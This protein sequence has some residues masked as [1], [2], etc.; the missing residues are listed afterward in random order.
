MADETQLIE[1]IFHAIPSFTGT[2]GLA[3]GVPLGIADDAM[4]LRG[5]GTKDL[6]VTV[7]AFV[8]GVHFWAD[9]HPAESVG[10]KALVRATSDIAAMG[11]KPLFF[12]LTLALPRAR[13]GRW[14]DGM[15]AGMGRSAR[16]LGLRLVGGDTTQAAAISMSLTVIGQVGRGRAVTRAGARPGDV[17]FVSG[18]LGA[19]QLG[20]ELVQRKLHRN[21]ELRGDIRP[22]FYP[23]IRVELGQ[24]LGERGVASAMIDLSDGLSSGLTRLCRASHVGA[25]IYEEKIPR[26]EISARVA[27]RLG[28]TKL[29]PLQ[30]AL[31]GGDDYELLFSVPKKHLKTLKKAA[32]GANIYEIGEICAGKTAA[33]VAR[34]GRERPFKP[35]GWDSFREK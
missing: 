14:L 31:H 11:A 10:Y 34:D 3:A 25:R 20:L 27:K 1:R 4:L 8:E 13:S 22:H 29:D 33:F 6:V 7:D 26:V 24:W 9:R 5:E 19:A 18:R 16:L 17:L 12:L 28:R 21:N 35:L 2:K 23:E 32:N 30:M 15:L